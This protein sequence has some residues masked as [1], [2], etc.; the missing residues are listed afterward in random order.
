[1]VN[2][3]EGELKQNALRYREAQD[4]LERK[5]KERRE[6]QQG[7]FGTD[8]EETEERA[9]QFFSKASRNGGGG[10]PSEV[11]RLREEEADLEEERDAAREDLLKLV[12]NLQLP[13]KEVID[14]GDS[15]VRFPFSE[16]VP[17]EVI[18]ALD[19]VLNGSVT[20]GEVTLKPEALVV[21]TE[22]VETAIDAAERFIG[23][24]RAQAGTEVEIEEYVEELRN[25]DE[26]VAKTLFILYEADGPLT[27]R[28]IE[29]RM[30]LEA[31]ELRGQIYYVVKN[32][33]YLQKEGEEFVLTETGRKVIEEYV[34]EYEEPV[35]AA[36]PQEVTE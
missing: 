18:E 15:I 1:M 12:M 16:E 5:R 23:D 20:G 32:D 34:A 29:T 24:L 21:K 22:D 14:P 3:M 6:A 4:R 35:N 33:P 11:D 27:K 25:R 10:K 17:S 31:G 30:G 19:E 26:K 13:F 9:R 2:S 28:E 8:S 36:Q 7:A